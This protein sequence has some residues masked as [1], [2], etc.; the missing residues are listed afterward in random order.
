M[1]EVD[2]RHPVEGDLLGRHFT[3]TGLSTAFEGTVAWHLEDER[4]TRLQEGSFQ[5]GSMGV[6]A[7]F[8]GEV[9]LDA[10]ISRPMPATLVVYGDNP[11]LPDGESPGISTNRVPVVLV[12]GMQGFV[13]HDVE[14]GDTLSRIAR[15]GDH[16]PSSVAAIVAANPG[17]IEDPDHIEVGWQLRVPLLS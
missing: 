2:V 3:V 13:L 4:G 16:G 7:E 11:A 6:F 12:P 5:G 8:S 15:D 14:R 10:A 1:R 9:T 17:L